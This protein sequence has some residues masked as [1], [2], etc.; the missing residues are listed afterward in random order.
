MWFINFLKKNKILTAIMLVHLFL[1][2]FIYDALGLVDF[3]TVNN[4]DFSLIIPFYY[5]GD[6]AFYWNATAILVFLFWLYKK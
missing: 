4:F 6:T 1:G 3:R 2:P 5:D